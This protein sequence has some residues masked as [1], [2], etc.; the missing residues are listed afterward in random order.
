LTPEE[1]DKIAD[2]LAERLSD[3]FITRNECQAERRLNGL[4]WK[5][6]LG[7]YVFTVSCAAFL[8]GLLW[9]RV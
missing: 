5:L 4:N 2:R 7:S 6:V 9:S 8:L 3:K 1:I